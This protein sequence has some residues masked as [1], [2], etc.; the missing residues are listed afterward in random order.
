MPT[1]ILQ[2]AV[3]L[4][5]LLF[6]VTALA[7]G[8]IVRRDGDDR[9]PSWLLGG[10][11]FT[12]HGANSVFQSVFGSW[13][14]VAG[15]GTAVYDAYLRWMAELNHSRTSTLVFAFAVLLFVVLRRFQPRKAFWFVFAC[16]YVVALGLGAWVGSA[17]NTLVAERHFMLVASLDTVELLLLFVLLFAMLVTDRVDR[18]F[19]FAIALYGFA[20]ALN[21]LWTSAL[22][23]INFT[24][25]PS[26][27]HMHAYRLV[28]TLGMLGIAWRRL[29]LARRGVAVPSLLG[30]ITAGRKVPLY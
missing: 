16:L 6:G 22:T 29:L 18:L 5:F 7:V 15:S 10:I 28:T 3:S 26:P 1:L 4:A 20:L 14:F 9:W 25:V 23:G 12:L 27:R 17:E 8:F 11:A 30:P 19:W 2:N 24:W 13:A 21:I